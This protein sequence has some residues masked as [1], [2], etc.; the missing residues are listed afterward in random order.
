MQ[1]FR[2]DPSFASFVNSTQNLNDDELDLK[3]VF[4]NE[5]LTQIFSKTSLKELNDL[6]KKPVFVNSELE[7][8]ISIHDAA[9]N[10]LSDFMLSQVF[11]ID[12]SLVDN[13]EDK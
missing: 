4:H 13:P 12:L 8:P 10:R 2:N 11:K 6:L 5:P 7:L 3:V 1:S 9:R